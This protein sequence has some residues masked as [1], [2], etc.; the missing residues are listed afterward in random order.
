[1]FC[2]CIHFL[3]RS[4]FVT[5]HVRISACTSKKRFL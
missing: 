5:H 1:V 3:K 4:V 2:R